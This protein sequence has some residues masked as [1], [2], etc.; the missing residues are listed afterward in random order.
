M[1]DLLNSRIRR[2]RPP[3]LRTGLRRLGREK[4][5]V[6]RGMFVK[7]LA[8]WPLRAA[9]RGL[10]RF[11]NREPNLIAFGSVRNRL[12]DNSAYLFLAMARDEELRC[13]WI[14]GSNKVVRNLRS[15]G[16]EAHSRWSLD[17]IRAAVRASFYVYSFA[18]SDINLWLVDGAV[19]LNL[20]HGLGV[21]RIERDRGAPWDR[22]YAAGGRSLTGRVFADDRRPPDW[23]LTPSAAMRDY[24]APPFAMPPDRCVQLGY[25]RNDHLVQRARP[26][27]ILVDPKTYDLL[28]QHPFVVGYFP[29]WRYDSFEALP[30][31]APSL[32]EIARAVSEHGGLT[33][34][35]PHHQS[36]TPVGSEQSLVF[37][38]ADC[39][40]NAY[41]GLCDVLIT[42][43]SSVAA[44]FLLLERPIIVFAPDVDEGIEMDRFSADPLTMQ[45]G[46]LAR[47]KEEMFELLRDIRS[48]PLPDNFAT[49]REHYWGS[50]TTDSAEAI[51]E[52]IKLKALGSRSSVPR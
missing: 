25:P 43:Y 13:V 52:F 39:D 34:F 41:L 45:P 29:T 1:E 6:Y 28:D 24:F 2:L 9:F 19:T 31:G 3:A 17:G 4:L 15:E 30:D 20:W 5:G 21:K 50:A 26:P 11:V 12:A 36:A 46:L 37:L 48:R 8:H 14:S 38:P 44:D 33:V 27:A 47:T 23:L 22:M 18:T 49:L 40:L 10:S 51:G 7:H 35:K 32:D 16:Y 42:D